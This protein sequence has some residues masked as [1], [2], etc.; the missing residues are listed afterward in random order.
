M[1][2][3]QYASRWPGIRERSTIVG[4]SR[5]DQSTSTA[6][7]SR[8]AMRPSL[9]ASYADVGLLYVSKIQNL[10]GGFGRDRILLRYPSPQRRK[11]AHIAAYTHSPLAFFTTWG[12]PVGT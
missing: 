1:I 12:S 3:R 9:K 6:E 5:T 8:Y 4:A 7:G 11:R 2:S 10:N